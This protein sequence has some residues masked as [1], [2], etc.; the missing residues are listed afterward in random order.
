M[1][2]E[3]CRGQTPSC[4]RVVREP[5]G[6]REERLLGVCWGPV[7]AC[8]PHPLPPLQPLDRVRFYSAERGQSVLD[9][10]V[11]LLVAGVLT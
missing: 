8:L 5:C 6:G 10:D 11:L 4:G 9:L 3:G 1:W 2:G 7:L